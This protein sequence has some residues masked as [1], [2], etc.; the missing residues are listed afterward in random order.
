MFCKSTWVLKLALLYLFHRKK[1][2][3]TIAC[4]A[5][6]FA[7]VNGLSFGPRYNFRAISRAET[8]VAKV[9]STNYWSYFEKLSETLDLVFH[10]LW[11]IEQYV[12]R[13]PDTSKSLKPFQP[14]SRCLVFDKLLHFYTKFTLTV[15]FRE[16]KALY[17]LRGTWGP[18]L[19]Y[20]WIWF[21]KPWIADWKGNSLLLLLVNPKRIIERH[22]M[23]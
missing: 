15:F 4:A 7:R 8:L 17:L 23:G 3:T 2:S 6:V 1:I 19:F 14:T 16:N 12:T 11:T 21:L 20:R 18:D 9:T 22:V 5:S 10:P 13:Y